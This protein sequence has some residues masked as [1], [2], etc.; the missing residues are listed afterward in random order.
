MHGNIQIIE[1]CSIIVIYEFENVK[2][3]WYLVINQNG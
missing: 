2:Y 3:I 1:R